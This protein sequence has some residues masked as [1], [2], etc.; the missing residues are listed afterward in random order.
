MVFTTDID[1][2]WE[3]FI[4]QKY[5]DELSSDNEEIDENNENN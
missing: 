5:D 2:E 1:T 4:S 3:N